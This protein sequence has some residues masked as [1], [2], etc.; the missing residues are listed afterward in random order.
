M[1]DVYRRWRVTLFVMWIALG[2]LAV[3]AVALVLVGKIP[4]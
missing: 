3:V 2:L 4:R 1:T